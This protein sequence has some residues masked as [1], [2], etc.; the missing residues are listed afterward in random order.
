MKHRKS[1]ILWKVVMEEVFDDLLRFIFPDADKIYDMKRGFEF[2]DKELAE[3]YPEP[4]KVT[5]TRYADKL[6]KVFNRKGIE[7]CVLL[8][9]EIQGDT[10]KRLQ[11]SERMYEYFARIRAR[12]P[13][14]PVSA[15]AI[16]TG[17]YGKNMPD[18][19]T[20]ECRRTRLTYEY[21]TISIL[22]FP[23][24]EL[25]ESDNPFA[26]VVLAAKASLL[27]GKIPEKALFERKVLIAKMLLAKGYSTRKIRAIFVFLESYVLFKDP[28]MNRN[29]RKEIK[30][31][32]KNDIMGID[33]YLKQEGKKEGLAEGIKKGMKEGMEKGI[34][35][36]QENSRRLF[37]ENLLKNSNF[38]VAKIASLANVTVEFV[39][40]VKN[41][42]KIK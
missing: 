1:D 36:G 4:E 12:H 16:F 30:S 28:K 7:E 14:K 18:R 33:E 27:E 17:Q 26:L 37:V 23:D 9:I 2:L 13:K 15:V 31:Q 38:S 10:S 41:G 32:D 24:K 22:D 35:K 40:K 29:F 11:F 42:L 8:H 21:P 5:A 25:T 6:V 39:N 19:Y 20:Y 34:E 3:M